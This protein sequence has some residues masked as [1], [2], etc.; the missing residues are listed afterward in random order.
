MQRINGVPCFEEKDIFKDHYVGAGWT[1][2]ASMITTC[3][4]YFDHCGHNY[5]VEDELVAAGV[6]T[7]ANKCDTESC[8]MFVYFRNKESGLR[9]IK[10][11]NDYLLYLSA[12]TSLTE[13]VA[14]YKSWLA[15][16]S[17]VNKLACDAALMDAAQ[18]GS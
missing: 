9:F 6:I 15:A 10:R 4:P 12:R 7:K 17:P 5:D 2:T 16:K 14:G 1:F 3:A 18:G 13:R 11:L 8:Q